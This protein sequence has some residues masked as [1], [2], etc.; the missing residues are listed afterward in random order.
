M[1]LELFYGRICNALAEEELH[2]LFDGRLD[3]A[4]KLAEKSQ[5][6]WDKCM[7]AARYG[8]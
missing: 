4:E 2:L 7:R 1:N 8:A 6:I 3:D 5:P